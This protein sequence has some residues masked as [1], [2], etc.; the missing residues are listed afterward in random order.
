MKNIST[1][2]GL[3]LLA[4]AIVAW[5]ILDRLM[6]N[7]NAV[8]IGTTAV[9][10]VAAAATAQGEPT[11]V[12]YDY[13][14]NAMWRAW[15]DGRVETKFGYWGGS[16][17]CTSIVTT[18]CGSA[19]GWVVFSDPAS[20]YSARFDGNCDDSIDGADLGLMLAAWGPVTR[21]PV[22]P[23]DCPLALINP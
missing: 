14:G 17:G 7:A 21:N 5:P 18:T 15:S 8:G 1:G 20:G 22:P 2:T 16:G 13:D 19:Q 11:I 6:P 4:G 3:A 9:T 23:S 12:W 10:A